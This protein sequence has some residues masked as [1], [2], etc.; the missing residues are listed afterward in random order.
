MPPVGATGKPKSVRFGDYTITEGIGEGGMCLVFRAR[1]DGESRDCALKLLRQDQRQDPKVLEMFLTEADISMLLRHPNLMKTYDAGDVKGRYYIAME[2]I[3]GASLAELQAEAR[4]RDVYFPPDFV[5]FILSEVLDGLEALHQATSPDGRSLGLVHRDVTPHNIFVGFDGRIILG[6]FGIAQIGAYGGAE[7]AGAMGKIGYLP[8][9][10][11]LGEEVDA[12]ADVFAVGVNLFELLTGSR[13]YDVGSDE[14]I[15]EEIV[16]GRIPRP[17]KLNQGITK[18]L[19]LEIM[20]ALARRPKDRFENAEEMLYALEP[21]WS[22]VIGN[23]R[24]LSALMTSLF[25]DKARRWLES[26]KRS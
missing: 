20:K 8:P 22:P 26:Q 17:R 7:V 4:R 12:R 23:P 9:E 11:L 21:H 5:M 13:L 3:E 15:M 6:D 2:L 19:E 25:R 16:E 1:R 18:G 24:A 10:A 14:E